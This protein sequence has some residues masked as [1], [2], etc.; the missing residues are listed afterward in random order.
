LTAIMR[1]A[2]TVT[3]ANAECGNGVSWSLELRRGATRQRLATGKAQ[4]QKAVK[5]GPIEGLGLQR[6]DLV[7]LLIGARDGNDSCDLAA[8]DM[9]LTSDGDAGWTWNLADDVSSNVLA[10]NP[11]DDR[12]GNPGVWHFYSESDKPGTEPGWVI[13]ADSLLAKWQTTAGAEARRQL[14]EDV[15]KLLTS[16]SPADKESPDA[17]LF[18]QLTSFGGPLFSGMLRAPSAERNV[19]EATSAESTRKGGTGQATSENVQPG[20][21]AAAS[22]DW[23]LDPA[24][25]GTHPAGGAVDADSIC[26]RAPSTI[27]FRLPAE[28]VAGCELVATCVLDNEHGAEGSVQLEVVAGQP[29]QEAGLHPSRVTVDNANGLWSSDNR[30]FTYGAPILVHESSAARKRWEGAFQDFRRLFPA[31]LCYAKI[32]PTDEVV[33]LTLFHREDD[34]LA[35]LMLDEAQQAELDRLWDELHYVS[36]DALTA[37]DALSQLIEFATQ[38][39]NPKVFEPLRQPFEQRA[40]DFRQRLIDSQPEQL[41]ALVDF[42]G[43]AYRRPLTPTESQNI[44]ALYGK[45]RAQDISHDE[46]FRLTL[47]RVLVA[48]AFLYRVE[49]P[50]PG[51]SQGPVSD[52][53]LASR[54]SYFLW[55][56]Q[57]DAELGRMAADGRLHDPDALAAQ[58]RRMLSDAKT[59]RLAIEF[60]CQWLH[61]HDFDHLDE[62]SERHFP[63]FVGLRGAMYEESIQFFTD[64]FQ[65]NGS[66]LDILDADYTFLN[67]ELAKHYGIPAGKASVPEKSPSVERPASAT[68]SPGWYRVDGVKQYGRGGILGQATTLAKQSGASRT[69]PILRGNWISEVLLGERL[70]RPPKGVPT[71]PDDESATAGLTVRQLVEKHS[72]DA[73]CAVCHRRIDP[74]GFALE[75]FDA[76]GRRREKDSGDR[77]I[78]TRVTTMDGAQFEGL[79]G[80]RN[81]LLTER[82]EAFQRQFCRKL[83]G[84]A[85]GR[86]VQLSDEPL[87]AEMQNV[88]RANDYK[89]VPALETIVRSRQFRE[90][91][92]ILAAYDD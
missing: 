51:A 88:L 48:P 41:D 83:L 90:I 85:L 16:D 34:Q 62:K 7:S 4:G 60:G 73:K 89:I 21:A 18:A 13:P 26:V 76:I 40:A 29:K 64:L 87:L 56:S 69:S 6:G 30:R 86:S 55:S 35:R 67:D 79:G 2:A 9:E 57:P 63:T 33:T 20:T 77:P 92:G 84:Y 45:L 65:N 47:A 80:L 8:I 11:H 44:R 38:D 1:V 3:P 25:F 71:L 54:L 17:A 23:G 59:R 74:L 19:A 53:E 50:G 31:A 15:Q 52:W 42:A 70:P 27:T 78:D 39:A 91:R 14:A 32:V 36:Q 28:L 24:L 75:G 12:F 5:V 81:Y 82:L 37:V 46:A 72:S 66:V 68:G 10:A 22:R 49:E 58:M 61:I 43:R